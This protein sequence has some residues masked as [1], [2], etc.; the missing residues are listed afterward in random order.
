M[1]V[2]RPPPDVRVDELLQGQHPCVQRLALE[3]LV[4]HRLS[5]QQVR[6]HARLQRA[7]V[8]QGSNKLR[9]KLVSSLSFKLTS[10]QQR[11][12]EE[13][14]ADLAS[15]E[16]MLR[17]VQ[18]DVGSGK[19]LVAAAAA[20]IAVDSGYQVA[21]MAPTEILA[22][23]HLLGFAELFEPL[24]LKICLLYTSPSPRDQRGSRMPSSA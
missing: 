2:H 12:I 7:P 6:A 13:I 8:M 20:A 15:V 19:T 24:G 11:V 9:S 23:Q 17:L 4:A 10:A 21:V 1:T 22:E 14:A 16:P 3:E 5:M 18:G